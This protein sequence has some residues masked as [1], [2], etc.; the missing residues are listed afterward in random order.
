MAG[1]SDVEGAGD[2]DWA[3]LGDCGLDDDGEAI[4]RSRLSCASDTLGRV[5][6]LFWPTRPGL[7]LS[8]RPVRGDGLCFFRAVAAELRVSGRVAWQLYKWT[9]VGMMKKRNH[10]LLEALQLDEYAVERRARLRRECPAQLASNA[11]WDGLPN[12]KVAL[13][14][15]NRKGGRGRDGRSATAAEG[16]AAHSPNSACT[17]GCQG[18]GQRRG[19]CGKG[20]SHAFPE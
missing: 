5:A 19:H 1:L 13:R 8:A 6:E 18:W 4:R 3:H 11:F 20:S 2:G 17:Q 14:A 9:L 12:W 10:Q 7:Q 15:G 16:T